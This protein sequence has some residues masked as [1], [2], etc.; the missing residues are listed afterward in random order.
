MA[1]PSSSAY[2]SSDDD[3]VLLPAPSTASAPASTSYRLIAPLPSSAPNS[4]GKRERGRSVGEAST[5]AQNYLRVNA[6]TDTNSGDAL[7]DD[8]GLE[9]EVLEKADD[10]KSSSN[11]TV[12]RHALPPKPSTSLAPLQRRLRLRREFVLIHHWYR[13]LQKFRKPRSK[14]AKLPT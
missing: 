6:S 3:E 9:D 2:A 7:D 12:L 8:N 4:H 11:K 1:S 14:R 13:N 5:S 10:S